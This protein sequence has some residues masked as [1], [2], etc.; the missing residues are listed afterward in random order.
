MILK[1][2]IVIIT[3]HLA[4]PCTDGAIRLHGSTRERIGRV[5]VCINASWGF[6]C[7]RSWDTMA[8]SVICNQLGF[9]PYGVLG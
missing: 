4:V 8:S 3:T 6:I 5:E 9:S 1:S 7:S 2:L